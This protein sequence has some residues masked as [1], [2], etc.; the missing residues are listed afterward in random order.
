MS[1]CDHLQRQLG[2]RFEVPR[3]DVRTGLEESIRA[4]APAGT[5]E[6]DIRDAVNEQ[7]EKGFLYVHDLRGASIPNAGPN[8][9]AIEWAN[10]FPMILWSLLAT[11]SIAAFQFGVAFTQGVRSMTNKAKCMRPRLVLKAIYL[12][13][14][15][16]PL[17]RT[18]TSVRRIAFSPPKRRQDDAKDTQDSQSPAKRANSTTEA[19]A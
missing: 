19:A 3:A 16:V 4:T 12:L 15:P 7:M 10:S 6:V 11:G 9:N 14:D 5:P 18:N 1:R 2:I 8:F 13:K 17:V